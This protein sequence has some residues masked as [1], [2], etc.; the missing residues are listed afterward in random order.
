M[1]NMSRAMRFSSDFVA[2]VGDLDLTEGSASLLEKIGKC[3]SRADFFNLVNGGG[4]DPYEF[5]AKGLVKKLDK[6]ARISLYSPSAY[7]PP[8]SYWLLARAAE[9]LGSVNHRPYCKFCF[10]TVQSSRLDGRNKDY[11]AIHSAGTETGNPAGYMRGRV[12]NDAFQIELS[13][14]FDNNNLVEVAKNLLCY[15]FNLFGKGGGDALFTLQNLKINE[16][17]WGDVLGLPVDTLRLD[18]LGSGYPDWTEVACRWRKLN[19][20]F[21]GAAEIEAGE[22][23]VT[24]A[25]LLT[26]WV[27]WRVWSM[28]GDKNSKIGRG[29]VPK[30]DADLAIQKRADGETSREIAAFFGVSK[31]AVDVFFSRRKKKASSEPH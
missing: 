8:E 26:Q 22:A 1:Y 25:M 17:Y 30:I 16:T 18:E 21:E 13:K 19:L 9:Y 27:R 10:R 14:S 28:A 4:L 6:Q 29:R 11:C 23:T 20:D 7:A 2:Q 31:V 15:Q 12:A 24:P 3:Q 5:D